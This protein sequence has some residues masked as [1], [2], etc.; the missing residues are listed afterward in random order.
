[1]SGRRRLIVVAVA[2]LLVVGALITVGRWEE[3]RA[4]R[5]EIAGMRAVLAAIG[6][7]RTRRPT[8]Y[9]LG[10]PDC[11]AYATTGNAFG[12][13]VCFDSAG[14]VVETVDRRGVQPK[15]S[16]LVYQP[17]L[18]TIR[19]PRTLVDQLLKLGPGKT[20]DSAGTGSG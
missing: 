5:H 20:G 11:L 6:N 13:Q 2:A 15:Y 10:P 7:L 18:S 9:R 1:L 8:G 14:R 3:H 16:S 4:A 12:L 19:V 17:S